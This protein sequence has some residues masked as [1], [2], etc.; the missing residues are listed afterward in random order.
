MASTC[1]RIVTLVV[2]TPPKQINRVLFAF[3]LFGLQILP[4]EMLSRRGFIL[5]ET[6]VLDDFVKV[7][8]A[9]PFCTRVLQR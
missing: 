1:V 8:P 7:P 5:P 4:G 6:L 3:V 9:V 2:V